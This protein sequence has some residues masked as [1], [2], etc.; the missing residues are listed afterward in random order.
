MTRLDVLLINPGGRRKAYQSLGAD[1][2]A[3]EPP[4][5]AGQIAEFVRRRGYSAA[6]LDAD[7]EELGPG[8]TAERA[9]ELRPLLTAVVVY[10]HNPSASTQVMP[11]AGEI[12]RA[13]REA[14]VPT[15]VLLLGGHVAAL[16]ERTVR[17][18]E[19]DFVCGGEGPCT[20]CELV[21]ALRA[22]GRAGDLEKVRDLWYRDEDGTIRNTPPAPLVQDLDREMP[23]VA[24]DLLPMDRYRAHNWHCFDGLEREPYGALYTTLGC[25]FR[26]TFCCIQAPFRSGERAL[27]LREGVN[28]YRRWSP[29]AVLRQLEVLVTKYGVRNVKFADEIFLLK[30]DHVEAICDG[31]I[32]RGWDL[33]IWAYARVDTL[34]DDLLEKLKK[35]GVNWL[36][37][38]IESGNAR[39]R[40]D[41]K[42]AF[43]PEK[44]ERGLA[45]LR[46]HG[47]A[48]CGNYIFGLP[49]DDEESMRDTLDLALEIKAEWGNFY[50]AMAYPGSELYRRAM[51]E[52]WPLPESWSGYSQLSVDTTPLP[53]RYLSPAEVLK[54][55]DHAFQVY[56]SDEGYLEVI[57]RRYGEK[58]VAHIR[59]M[60]HRKLERA[61]YR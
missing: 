41:V 50:C 12:C 1:L 56:Y 33:N 16:P 28:S 7:A 42:K 60:A 37:L 2:A 8:E 11:A 4:I 51:A 59:E 45:K 35:A 17:D 31:I 34:Y 48:V 57:R 44:L 26:C 43:T 49:E 55:R 25:P 27:G 5:W 14:A 54:F 38:G 24:W 30:T 18:E 36:A 40:K 52:G 58:T 15:R 23:G 39:V 13:I 29:A 19:A 53:T 46:R 61:L 21:E 32:D 47:I 10:G 6:I 9:A 20:V 22:G 3:V